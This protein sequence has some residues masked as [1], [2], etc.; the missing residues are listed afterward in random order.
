MI[1]SA[2]MAES[3]VIEL[4]LMRSFGVEYLRQP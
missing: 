4:M 1:G 2:S 3:D